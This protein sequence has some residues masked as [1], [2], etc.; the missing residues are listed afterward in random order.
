[1]CLKEWTLIQFEDVRAS[2]S[3][4]KAYMAHDQAVGESLK[5][6]SIHYDDNAYV[7]A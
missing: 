7:L 6:V 1:M 4:R 5:A 3:A 2:T